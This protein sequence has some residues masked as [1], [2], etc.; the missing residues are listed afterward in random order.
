MFHSLRQIESSYWHTLNFES[1][2][3][4]CVVMNFKTN[5]QINCLKKLHKQLAHPTPLFTKVN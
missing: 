5:G 2:F 4:I 1:I 3:R